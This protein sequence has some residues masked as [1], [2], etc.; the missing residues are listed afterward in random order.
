MAETIFKGNPTL[1]TERLILR[2]L[3]P[4]DAQDIFAYASDADVTEYVL[5]PTH[6]TTE[7][8]RAFISFTLERYEKDLAGDWGV[9][10]KENGRLIGT[11][12]FRWADMDNRSGEIGYVLA[13]QYWG[14]GIIPEAAGRVLK[15]AFEEMGL[16][17]IECYHL[18][19]NEKSGRVMQKLGMTYEGT[20]REET[21]AKGRFWDV[22]Q[23]AILKSDWE[24]S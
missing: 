23:Y 10:L 2:R 21:F 11:V 16:N 6:K 18:L 12:G 14:Q 13:K 19:P 1:E 22:K 20:A 24:K 3:A 5:W 8:S 9:V 15:F 17:R 4:D 7:D